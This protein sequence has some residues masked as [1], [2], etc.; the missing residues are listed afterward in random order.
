MQLDSSFTFMVQGSIDSSP[1]KESFITLEL[2]K[3]IRLFHPQSPII[4]STWNGIEVSE[5]KGISN[6]VIL[7]NEDPGPLKFHTEKTNNVNRMI[8]SSLHGLNHVKTKNVIKLRTDMILYKPL[9]LNYFQKF[10]EYDFSFKVVSE[11]IVCISYSSVNPKFSREKLLFHPCDWLFIGNIDDVKLLYKGP[12]VSISD[13]A[14]FIDKP[15]L[16]DNNY[17]AKYR[18]EQFLFLNLIHNTGHKIEKFKD[19]FSFSKG[20]ENLSE[21][22]ISNNLV[23]I[24][25]RHL[26]LKSMK[27]KALSRVSPNRLNH[28]D[29]LRFYNKHSVTN[30]E[31]PHFKFF[32][33]DCVDFVLS[34][35]IHLKNILR[36]L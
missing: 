22:Y 6:L 33:I 21:K 13:A 17:I 36:K 28:K 30:G 10:N 23:I 9:G 25:A 35:L 15:N 27:H 16:L 3:S 2:I 18:A 5:F 7:F 1:F 31:Y 12:L 19:A 24:E 34:K 14:N 11:R 26:G 32:I 4:L 20:L 8:V 29:W